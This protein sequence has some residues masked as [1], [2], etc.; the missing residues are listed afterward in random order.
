MP[1]ELVKKTELLG[2]LTAPSFK[3]SAV[4]RNYGALDM[5]RAIDAPTLCVGQLE[6]LHG[7]EALQTA[8]GRLMA[9]AAMWHEVELS[10]SKL[11]ALYAA[12]ISDYELR[13][14]LPD[15]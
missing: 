3:Q 4:I 5:Q 1:K 15:P 12:I 6:K 14:G 9:S 10:R 2:A 7:E 8:I 13:S 11:D